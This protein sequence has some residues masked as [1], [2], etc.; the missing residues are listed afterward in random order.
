MS[1]LW[2]QTHR[3]MIR[4]ARGPDVVRAQS[5]L[6][7]MGASPQLT[8]DG[9]FG[10]NTERAV[11]EFQDMFNLEPDGKLGPVTQSVLFT[12]SYRVE[13][14]RP[15]FVAQGNPHR[16]WAAC[17]EAVLGVSWMG[18][19]RRTMAQL[20]TTY[21]AHIG[22]HGDIT[23]GGLTGV[24]ATDFNFVPIFV[25]TTIRAEGLLRALRGRKPILIV[26]NSSGAI[27]HARII[28]G[29]KI[30]AGAIDVLMM[31]PMAGYVEIPIGGLQSLSRIGLFAPREASI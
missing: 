21:A 26:D 5:A 15:P 20:A 27:M 9:A 28:Y 19:P 1:N 13:L 29:V 7:D 17:L 6:N 22:A 3:M 4:G 12:G 24:V 25:G 31:D 14:V 30:R 16:C 10:E 23:V 2:W 11:R 8:P 18:R